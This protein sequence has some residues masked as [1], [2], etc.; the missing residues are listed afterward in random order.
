MKTLAEKLTEARERRGWSQNRAAEELGLSRNV[1]TALEGTNPERNPSP[2]DIRLT[3]AVRILKG[4]WPEITLEDLLPG[5]AFAA[6]PSGTATVLSERD[7]VVLLAVQRPRPEGS[8]VETNP[9]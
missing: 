6:I 4:Y 5:A 8:P 7:D 1:L 3:T 9:L 2:G